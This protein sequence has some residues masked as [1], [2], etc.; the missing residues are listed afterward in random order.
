MTA[1]TTPVQTPTSSLLNLVT[2]VR[3]YF[4]AV[5]PAVRVGLTGW[6]ER[7]KH[8]NQGTPAANRVLFIP[9][10][11]QGRD[12]VLLPGRQTQA[13]PRNLLEWDRRVLMSVWGVAPAAEDLANDEAQLAAVELLLEQAFQAVVRAAVVGV[14][15]P[16]RQAGAI[17]WGSV[18]WT[19]D[20]KDLGLGRE[21]L[22]D[23]TLK[24]T[25]F[26]APMGFVV[27]TPV[28]NRDPAT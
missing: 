28:L 21:V 7:A 6:R 1:A 9:G 14:G 12:G 8:L 22:V 25:F 3:T 23:F 27:P 4:A 13:N 15:F 19:L 5:N 20:N 26:D 11:S 16:S 24:S 2:R 17:H 18:N 10:D